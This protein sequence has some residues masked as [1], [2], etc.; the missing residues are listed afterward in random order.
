MASLVLRQCSPSPSN[1][2]SRPRL[3]IA[4]GRSLD[5][6]RAAWRLRGDL[7]GD[8]VDEWTDQCWPTWRWA[9]EEYSPLLCKS[10][11]STPIPLTTNI[12]TLPGEPRKSGAGRTIN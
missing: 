3:E 5:A 9:K 2:T 7:D 8:Q 12:L 11:Q 1:V 6:D 10:G 4:L